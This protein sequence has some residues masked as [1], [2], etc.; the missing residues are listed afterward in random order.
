M[1][2]YSYEEAAVL[3]K[4]NLKSAQTTFSALDQDLAFLKDQIT[5]QEVNIARVHNFNVGLKAKKSN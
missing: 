4:L 5:T 1:V 3:L 2:K